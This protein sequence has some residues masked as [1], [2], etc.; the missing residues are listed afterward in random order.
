MKSVSIYIDA[1]LMKEC[2]EIY[3]EACCQ[4]REKRSQVRARVGALLGAIIFV[5]WAA[6]TCFDQTRHRQRIIDVILSLVPSFPNARQ[7]TTSRLP[8]TYGQFTS[9]LA[10]SR[11]P[12]RATSD[13]HRSHPLPI[14]SSSNPSHERTTNGSTLSLEFRNFEE[15]E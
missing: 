2:M 7:T 14:L 9:H 4:L 8:P 3:V 5:Q 12:T 1:G 13:S 11:S 15:I 10:L 6:S